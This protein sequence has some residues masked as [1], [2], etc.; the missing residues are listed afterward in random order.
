LACIVMAVPQA[1]IVLGLIA[2]GLWGFALAVWAV[3]AAQLY[4]MAD[5]LRAPREKAPWYNA[6]GTTLYVLGMLVT[7]FAIGSIS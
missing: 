1:I 4:L 6:T 7:A 3:L 2:M 5:L